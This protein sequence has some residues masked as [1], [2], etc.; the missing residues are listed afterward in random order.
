[1]I[2]NKKLYQPQ[3]LSINTFT[4]DKPDEVELLGL[5]IDQEQNFKE[6]FDKLCH[7]VQFKLHAVRQ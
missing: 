3:K 4:I 5:N 7:N 2:L 1:M 6:H